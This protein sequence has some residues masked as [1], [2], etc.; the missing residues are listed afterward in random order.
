MLTQTEKTRVTGLVE[1]PAGLV[2]SF[3]IVEPLESWPVDAD[4]M[5]TR[6]VALTDA[7]AEFYAY[8]PPVRL[9]SDFDPRALSISCNRFRM[10]TPVVTFSRARCAPP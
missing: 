9:A 4:S 8:R 10:R 5:I 7:C 1:Y 2:P 3:W 6:A